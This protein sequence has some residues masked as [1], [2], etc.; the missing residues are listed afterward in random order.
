[1]TEDRWDKKPDGKLVEEAE[2]G[3]HGQGAVVEMMRQLKDS[4]VE[5]QKSTNRLTLVIIGLTVA[6]VFLAIV[7]VGPA[8][9]Q[10]MK[11]LNGSM[12]RW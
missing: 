11:G 1:M 3:L 10:L 5:Q 7:Q 2:I 12:G 9:L 6:L 4:L 8:L